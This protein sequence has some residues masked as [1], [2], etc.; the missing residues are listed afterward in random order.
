[1]SRPLLSLGISQL[2][3]RFI[4]S[5]EDLTQL[6]ILLAELLFRSTPKATALRSKVKKA[7]AVIN[8][9]DLFEPAKATE[10]PQDA[11]SLTTIDAKTTTAENSGTISSVTNESPTLPQQQKPISKSAATPTTTSTTK[12]FVGS[13]SSTELGL[14]EACT[15]FKI[16]LNERWEVI[17]QL[18]QDIVGRSSP[19]AIVDL[20]EK[21]KSDRRSEAKLANTAYLVILQGRSDD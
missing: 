21:E 19:T 20:S 2:E 7:I 15:F 9:D 6:E 3:A 10:L 16:K 8:G 4:S 11:G 18:R 1:M 5:T 17:E 14:E 13:T 12:V